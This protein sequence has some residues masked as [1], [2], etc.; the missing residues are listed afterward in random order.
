ML[1]AMIRRSSRRPLFVVRSVPELFVVRKNAYLL[2]FILKVSCPDHMFLQHC[3]AGS[4]GRTLLT[5]WDCVKIITSDFVVVTFTT[6]TT[7]YTNH[8]V[9]IIGNSGGSI[10]DRCD[11]VRNKPKVR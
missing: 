6:A 11:L 1:L 7:S 10:P 5:I 4:L 9:P 2:Y 3:A 8:K